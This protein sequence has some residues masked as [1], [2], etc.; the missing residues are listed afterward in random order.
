MAEF[1]IRGAGIFG[2]SIAWVLTRRGAR[3]QVVDPR[4]LGLPNRH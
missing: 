3:V 2:L 4:P 1:T